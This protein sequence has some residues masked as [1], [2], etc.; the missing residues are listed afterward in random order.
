MGTLLAIDPGSS[1]S[2]WVLIDVDTRRPLRFE[3][4]ENHA[5]RVLIA[6]GRLPA[7]RAV[8]EMVA[9]YGMAVGAEVFSTCVWI[10]RFVEVLGDVD[11]DLVKRLPVRVHH[12]HSPKAGDPNVRQALVDRFAPGERNHGKG[13][14]AAPGFFYGFHDDIWQAFA[15]AVY[16]ADTLQPSAPEPREARPS[17][18]T[19]PDDCYR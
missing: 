12:C 1:E 13:T 15:L 18:S 8:I 10:G 5:L 7:D 14:K 3:K 6:A 17:Q 4:T 19:P 16:A 9:S 11:V 2:G